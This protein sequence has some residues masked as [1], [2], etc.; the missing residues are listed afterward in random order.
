[1]TVA[2]TQFAEQCFA[3]GLSEIFDVSRDN[4]LTMNFYGPLVGL[5][6]MKFP[7]HW[8]DTCNCQYGK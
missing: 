2:L 1:M 7:I 6:A 8:I 4:S 5:Y 3:S